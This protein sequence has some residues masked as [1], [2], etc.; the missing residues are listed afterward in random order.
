MTEPTSDDGRTFQRENAVV[1]VRV[2]ASSN[3]HPVGTGGGQVVGA[4]R[5]GGRSPF[6]TPSPSGP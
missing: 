4:A 3:R 5:Q 1:I 2:P 6:C